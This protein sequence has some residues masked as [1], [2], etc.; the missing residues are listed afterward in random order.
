MSDQKVSFNGRRRA[1]RYALQALYGWTLSQNNLADVESYTLS[2]H[3]E[4]EI[5]SA[6][7]HLLLHSIPAELSLLDTL[8]EPYVSRQMHDLGLIERT[9]LRMAVY[10]L[11]EQKEI[12]YRVIIN[13]ALELAKTFAAP[14]SHKFVNG[15]LDKVRKDL[16]PL[17]N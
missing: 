14:E 17:E 2:E 9:I 10:E 4:G 16:R 1:R 7:F 13:E 11:K 8:F 3:K 5:D 6:Y 15:I 12:P